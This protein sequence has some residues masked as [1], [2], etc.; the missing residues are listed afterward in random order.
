MHSFNRLSA[1]AVHGEVADVDCL[2]FPDSGR[3]R[4]IAMIRFAD[5]A[6]TNVLARSTLRS[7]EC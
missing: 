5:E 2:T 6:G 4:G 3:F 1:P 7:F